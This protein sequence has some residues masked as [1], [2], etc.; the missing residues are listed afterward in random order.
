MD[1]SLLLEIYALFYQQ[2]LWPAELPG[3]GTFLP[4]VKWIPQGSFKTRG[5]LSGID[6]YG[7]VSLFE[8]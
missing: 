8:K 3:D 7:R 2:K 5:K 6:A 4:F 1:M